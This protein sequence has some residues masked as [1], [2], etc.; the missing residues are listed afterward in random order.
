[1]GARRRSRTESSRIPHPIYFRCRSLAFPALGQLPARAVPALEGV[2][3][4]LA[5][6]RGKPFE[7]ERTRWA[8]SGAKPRAPSALGRWRIVSKKAPPSPGG[9]ERTLALGRFLLDEL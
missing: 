1:M 4:I 6:A 7:C 3:S 9:T 2:R 8:A 5:F